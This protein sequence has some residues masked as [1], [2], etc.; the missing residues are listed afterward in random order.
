MTDFFGLPAFKPMYGFGDTATL[1]T[2]M[3]VAFVGGAD[4]RAVAGAVPA[5]PK[6]RPIASAPL[7]V[8]QSEFTS[9][10][11]N[12]DPDDNVH[13]YNEVML[14]VVVEGVGTPVPALFP[15]ILFV[16]D[17]LPMVSGREY[18]G[19]PK[20]LG[21]VALGP[22]SAAVRYTYYPRGVK[23]VTE[24][25]KARWDTQPGIVARALSGLG[26]LLTAAVRGAGVDE[27]TIDL[28]GALALAPAGQ[29]LNVRQLPDLSNPRR[30][31]VSEL[32]RFAPRLIDPG[33]PVL[34]Q[35]HA[36]ELPDEP[37]WSLGRRFFRGGSPRTLAAFSWSVTMQVT[38]GEVIDTW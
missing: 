1:R 17:P 13:R 26:E 10:T 2:N 22:G 18:Y 8:V 15:L 28:V 24:V 16:D 27:D 37:V 7:V 35:G 30:A 36:L 19:F 9:A 38:T 33:A 4:G 31:R 12:G 5:H 6:L 14:A 21:E 29:I 23:K 25:L 20:V 34:V 11:D 3:V 32:T